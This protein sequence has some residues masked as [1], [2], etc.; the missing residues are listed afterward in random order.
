M[1]LFLFLSAVVPGRAVVVPLT[2]ENS[3]VSRRGLHAVLTA[4][5]RVDG[6]TN[7]RIRLRRKGITAFVRSGRADAGET[8]R[9][10]LHHRIDQI[11]LARTPGI[12]VKVKKP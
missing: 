8:V 7:V 9:A 3:G 6:V 5:A 10:A 1:G 4:A 11:V 12:T 2:G